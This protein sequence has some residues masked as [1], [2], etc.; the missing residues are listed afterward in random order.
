[1]IKYQL[2]GN[3]LTSNPNDRMAQETDARTY[4]REDIIEAMLK[5]G[6]SLTRSDILA[7]QNLE[8]EVLSDIIAEGGHIHTP[9]LT[10][11]FSISGVFEDQ[12]D[13]FDKARHTVR[14]NVNAGSALREAATKVKVQK[15]EGNSTDP[16]ISSVID[17]VSGDNTNVKLGSVVEIKGVRLKFDP[18]DSDQGVFAMAGGAEYRCDAIIENMPARVLVMLPSS[19]PEG[20][21][22]LEVRTKLT[23]NNSSGKLLKRGSYGTLLK[24]VR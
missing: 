14:L 10:T 9:I 1:M 2:R 24:A 12:N 23:S 17:K 5:R 15:V 11:S 13:T 22:I 16:N 4:T 21:F 3:P 8:I 18:A 19:L 20:E 6:T 7:Y